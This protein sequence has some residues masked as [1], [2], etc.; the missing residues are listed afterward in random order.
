MAGGLDKLILD[1]LYDDATERS[2]Q[3]DLWE[4]APVANA[5]M[6]QPARIAIPKETAMS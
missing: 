3:Y 4:V 6:Q 2:N 5:M 1:S